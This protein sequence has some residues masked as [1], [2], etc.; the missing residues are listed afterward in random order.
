MNEEIIILAPLSDSE[1]KALTAYMTLL[2]HT[3]I[4][5]VSVNKPASQGMTESFK[6]VDNVD[7]M[8]EEEIKEISE[9]FSRLGKMSSVTAEELMKV[10]SA[11]RETFIESPKPTAN[12]HK[13]N[14]N[15]EKFR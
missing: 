11:L 8:K 2:Q 4:K 1:I 5:Y 9:K 6:I 15:N 3:S 14:H 10:G 13:R 12:P 7:A